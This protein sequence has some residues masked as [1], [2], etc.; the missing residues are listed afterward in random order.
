MTPDVVAGGGYTWDSYDRRSGELTTHRE[1]GPPCLCG[2]LDLPHPPGLPGCRGVVGA[3]TP[4]PLAPI[5]LTWTDYRTRPNEWLVEVGEGEGCTHS[6]GHQDLGDAL[7]MIRILAK[8]RVTGGEERMNV[9]VHEIAVDGLPDMDNDD[10]TGR[11]AFVFDGCVVSGW[12]L[13]RVG[14]PHLWEANTDV[15][16]NQ[17]FGGVTHWIEFP[18]PVS[19][20]GRRT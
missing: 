10:L 14:Q 15:G 3:V 2:G 18:V 19:W 4:E 9:I 12:P 6:T 1:D 5:T 20:I 8:Q 7:N 17:P 11:I 16:H 13:T